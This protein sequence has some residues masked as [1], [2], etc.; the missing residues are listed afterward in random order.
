MDVVGESGGGQLTH[1]PL[2]TR[3]PVLPK[4]KLMLRKLRNLVQIT[5][6]SPGGAQPHIQVGLVV[7]CVTLVASFLESEPLWVP[8]KGRAEM[9][10]LNQPP[11]GPL[12]HG[13]WQLPT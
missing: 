10:S 11:P 8:A 3:Q 4:S 12:S 9:S 6:L 5:R 1:G 7:K 13:A 2:S